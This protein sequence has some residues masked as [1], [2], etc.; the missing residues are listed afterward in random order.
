M[1][2]AQLPPNLDLAQLPA[3]RPPQGTSSNFINPVTLKTP[4]VAI[5]VVFL[6]LATLFVI[7]RL[8]TRRFLNRALGPEDCVYLN[9][10]N[11]SRSY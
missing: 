2:P 4:V 8:Y 11:D 6:S 9:P 3:G 1:N 7:L 5:N 10:L